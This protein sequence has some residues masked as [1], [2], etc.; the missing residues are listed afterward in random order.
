MRPAI[1]EN[2]LESS[3]RPARRRGVDLA[4]PGPLPDELARGLKGRLMRLNGIG[5]EEKSNKLLLK[6]CST[7][8]DLNPVGSRI[9]VLADLVGLSRAQFVCQ[10]TMLPLRRAIA[11]KDAGKSHGSDEDRSWRVPYMLAPD[12]V[13]AYFCSECIVEDIDFHGVTYWRRDHQLPG[14]YCCGKHAEP[15]MYS[16]APDS[17]LQSP[18]H[19]VSTSLK[20]KDVWARRTEENKA[21]QRFLFLQSELLSRPVPLDA[22]GVAAL[23]RKECLEHGLTVGKGKRNQPKLLSEALVATYGKEWLSTVVRE[24]AGRVDGKFFRSVDIVIPRLSVSV[25]L[26]A[27]AMLKD[28]GPSALNELIAAGE[29]GDAPS[30][31]GRSERV[32]LEALRRLYIRHDGCHNRIAA[33]INKFPGHVKHN[34]DRIGLPTLVGQ[35]IDQMDRQLQDFVFGGQSIAESCENDPLKA[36]SFERLLR[37]TAINLACAV[38]QMQ[39]TKRRLRRGKQ[40]PPQE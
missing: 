16:L 29:S 3:V 8:L 30:D 14:R 4:I 38:H 25:M 1:Q 5:G 36:E 11:F 20:V 17:F 35:N 37:K 2:R 10:H 15:L 24:F 34:L 21:V 13:G 6:T 22:R 40:A 28:D 19:V 32:D 7:D 39:E 33:E 26:A 18:F 9:D 31:Y 12:R 27:L 23:L